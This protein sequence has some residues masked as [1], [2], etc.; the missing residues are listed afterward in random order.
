MQAAGS[1]Q[2][3]VTIVIVAAATMAVA[4][5]VRQCLGLFLGPVGTDLAVSAASFGFAVAL[6]NL[7]WGLSQPLL[8]ALGDRFGPRPVL[9]GSALLY[10]AG[11][12][13]LAVSR[14]ALLGL[15]LGIGVLAGIGVAGTGFG[16]L[17]GTVS[18]AAP[19]GRQ[20]QLVGLVSGIG[21]LGVLALAPLGQHVIGAG[22]WRLAAA[23][24]GA[25]CLA[26]VGLAAFVPGA[27]D[28]S[29]RPAIPR[30]RPKVGPALRAAAGH[31]G[32]VAMTLAFFAC[33]FQLMFITTHLPRFLGLCGMPP[34]LG[35]SAL[36]V[37]GLCNAIGT[38]GF[39]LLGA[40]YSRKRLLALIYAIR[41]V[42]IAAY[43]ATPV[44][45]GSTLL[46][47]AVM[48]FTWLGVVPLVSG[49][50]AR[51]FGLANFNLLFGVT[52]L[53]HQIGSFVG[54]WAGGLVL[55]LTGRYDDAWYAM[56][57]IG[58]AATLLQWPMD[59]RPRLAPAPA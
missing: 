8:G 6:H 3:L 45:E 9:I 4:N 1:Q 56:L 59:D 20:S 13:L 16:V 37:I 22:G 5:G 34:S 27:P 41:T 7:V 53:C 18:R 32:F 31:G 2:R 57:A 36:G 55:D 48:G 21:S 51:L 19:P 30:E 47:A 49:L 50:I 29:A 58:L 23:A 10:A 28:R 14:S 11:L 24:Y 38:Y 26:M 44:T 25:L 35:A 46:F 42:A 17:L 52:F 33:G 43:I 39:G 54:A 40:R 15:D 12:A